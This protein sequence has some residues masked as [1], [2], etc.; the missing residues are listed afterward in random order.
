MSLV[1][2][3]EYYAE[4][5]WRYMY[6]QDAKIKNGWTKG[7]LVFFAEKEQLATNTPIYS[8]Y[9]EDPWRFNYSRSAEVSNNWKKGGIEF[10]GQKDPGTGMMPVF[11]YYAENPWRTML[12]M[13][14]DHGNGWTRDAILFYALPGAAAIR[15]AGADI[16]FLDPVIPD[17]RPDLIGSQLILNDEGTTTIVQQ[18]SMS[19]R[20]TSVFEWSLSQKITDSYNAK[21]TGNLDKFG[22]IEAG[23]KLGIELGAKQQWTTSQETV[24]EINESVTVPPLSRVKVTGV[25]KWLDQVIS[26]FKMTMKMVA[27]DGLKLSGKEVADIFLWKNPEISLISTTNDTALFAIYGKFTGS[28]GLETEIKTERVAPV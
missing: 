2:V 16:E 13:N 8:H 25:V 17:A 15:C 7:D 28:Y 20:M 26:P 22:G 9:A 14:P 6:S 21:V 12:S 1:P 23:F 18:I 19:R 10:Y 5:I 11:L 4:G 27:A 3:Y 24:Y